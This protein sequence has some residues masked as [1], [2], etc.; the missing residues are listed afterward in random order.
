MKKTQFFLSFVICASLYAME[1]KDVSS[2][3]Y[4]AIEESDVFLADKLA[5]NPSNTVKLNY[6]DPSEKRT[7]FDKAVSEASIQSLFFYFG[8]LEIS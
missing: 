3:L 1:Q 5:K 4:A 2:D 7:L 6:I 8:D